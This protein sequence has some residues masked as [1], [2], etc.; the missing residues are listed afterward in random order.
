MKRI[1]SIF[2]IFTVCTACDLNSLWKDIK[3]KSELEKLPPITQTGEN[4]FGCLT[5]GKAMVANNSLYVTAIYQGG[6]LQIGGQ[7][8]KSDTSQSVRILV[9]D[10]IVVGETYDLKNEVTGGKA[11]F[12]R[13]KDVHECRYEAEHIFEGKITYSKIDRTNFVVSGTFEFSASNETCDTVRVADGRFDI[14][15][16]P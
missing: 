2:L 6:I 3:P 16:T 8:D 1:L 11:K 5:N 14:Q 12:L 4:T 9:L 13:Y 15:Y 10:P 7:M